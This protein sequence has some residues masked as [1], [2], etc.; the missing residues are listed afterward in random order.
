MATPLRLVRAL[1]RAALSGGCGHPPTSEGRREAGR[2][3]CACGIVRS[4]E[5][6]KRALFQFNF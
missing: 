4:D 2:P 3:E 6:E 1:G 5:A